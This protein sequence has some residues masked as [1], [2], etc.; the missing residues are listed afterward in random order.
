MTQIWTP[1][2]VQRELREHT[3]QHTQVTLGMF[4]PDDPVCAEWTR[5]LQQLDPWLRL[6]KA[7]PRAAG[8]NV[9]A[10]FYHLIRINVGAPLWVMPLTEPDG[11]FMEPS[12]AMLEGLRMADLQSTRAVK[13][14]KALDEQSRREKA[15]A[16]AREDADR[17]TE[18]LERWEAASDVRINFDPDK[19]WRQNQSGRDREGK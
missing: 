4:E 5:E 17:Q 19:P 9:I 11:S 3:Q 8:M 13:A 18:I 16:D 15:S 7:K 6:G 10:G 2:K 12:S 1:P 14:R